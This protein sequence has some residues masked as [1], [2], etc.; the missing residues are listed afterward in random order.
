MVIDSFY[1]VLNVNGFF[2]FLNLIALLTEHHMWLS[3]LSLVANNFMMTPLQ[4][5]VTTYP[6]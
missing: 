4:A 3:T 5:P 2:L 6:T 1:R